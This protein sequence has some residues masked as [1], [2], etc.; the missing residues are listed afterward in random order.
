MISTV[1]VFFFTSFSIKINETKKRKKK[2]SR[3]APQNLLLKHDQVGSL[4]GHV[5]PLLA[6]N[7]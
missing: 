7:Y 3:N 2:E 1:N 5:I 6:T 4:V